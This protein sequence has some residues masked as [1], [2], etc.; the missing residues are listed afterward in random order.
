MQLIL[1]PK[2]DFKEVNHF[3]KSHYNPSHLIA[4]SDTPSGTII[5]STEDAI[6][7]E[8]IEKF[9]TASDIPK[10]IQAKMTIDG[11]FGSWSGNKS[12]IRQIRK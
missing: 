2:P 5:A 6:I 4:I 7:E 10:P 12:I 3:F 9:P 8:F 11:L 1:I